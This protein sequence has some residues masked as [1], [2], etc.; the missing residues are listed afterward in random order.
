MVSIVTWLWQGKRA[1]LPEHVNVLARMFKRTLSIPH[2]LICITD[3]TEG[4]SDDVEVMQ[5]PESAKWLTGFKSPEG[6]GFPSCYRRL[7]MFSDDAKCLGKQVLL[8]DIDMVVLRDAAHLFKQRA[9]FV[10]W[11][12]RSR[13]GGPD[14]VGGGIYLLRTGAHTDVY[15]DFCGYRSIQ[16][17]REAGFRGSDQA[18]LS[19]KLQ[20]CAVWPHDCGIVSQHEISRDDGRACIVQ[21]NGNVKPWAAKGWPATHW[22]ME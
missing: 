17:A 21:Y 19:Y 9:S 8:V 12:P 7:W 15:E 20:G 10:G 18:W 13:W 22:R 2:Q 16:E 5:T 4:F 6:E 14:R 3:T 1:Y 11:R